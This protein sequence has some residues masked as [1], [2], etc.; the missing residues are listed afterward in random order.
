MTT[1]NINGINPAR[2]ATKATADSVVT[3]ARALAAS[4]AVLDNNRLVDAQNFTIAARASSQR[5]VDELAAHVD[6]LEQLD[7]VIN[8]DGQ[9]ASE[10]DAPVTP[11]LPVEPPAPAA[12]PTTAQTPPVAIANAVVIGGV[13]NNNNPIHWRGWTLLWAFVGALITSTIAALFWALFVQEWFWGHGDKWLILAVLL[14]IVYWV[15]SVFAGFF[16]GGYAALSFA[17]RRMAAVAVPVVAIPA[18]PVAPVP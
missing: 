1:R 3:R 9:P 10:P 15:G 5:Y 8:G 4:V 16:G 11:V 14:S 18:P 6:E 7:F 13:H 2:R 12:D 17:E